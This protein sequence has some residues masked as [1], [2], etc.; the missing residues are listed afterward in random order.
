M[1]MNNNKT[2]ILV[3][4]GIIIALAYVLSMIKVYEM[5]NGGSVTAVSMLPILIFATRWGAKPGIFVAATYGLLQLLLGPK[6]SAHPASI[7]L[8]Y[9]LGFGVLG[10]AGMFGKD[11]IKSLMGGVLTMSARFCFSVISGIVAYNVDFVG[12]LIYNATYMVPE[13]VLTVVAYSLVFKPLQKINASVA[14][15]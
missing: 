3:E 9:I 11:Y 14:N 13:M 8:D 1:T 7:I 12:S 2:R 5:P 6:F 10:L 4:G 15:R